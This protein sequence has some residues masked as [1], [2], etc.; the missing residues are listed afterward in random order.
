MP[1]MTFIGNIGYVAVS[2]LGGWLAV[3]RTIAVGDILAFVQYVRSFTQPIA[4]VAQIAN[5][6][7]STAAAAERVFNFRRRRGSAKQKIQ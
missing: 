6:L 4:Q 2:I 7:Q 5:V 1:I 3:K